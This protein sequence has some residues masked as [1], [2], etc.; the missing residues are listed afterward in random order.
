M[1]IRQLFLPSI[2]VIPTLIAGCALESDP[3]AEQ[4]AVRA[5][6]ALIPGP[7][8]WSSCPILASCFTVTNT[9]DSGAGSLRQAILDANA[10]SGE[11]IIKFDIPGNGPHV[12]QPVQYLPMLLGDTTIDGFSQTGAA[13]ATETSPPQIQIVVNG[14]LSTGFWGLNLG[15]GGNLVQGLTVNDFYP[16][17]AIVINSDDNVVRSNML[18]VDRAATFA[19]PN[20]QAGVLINTGSNNQ[21]GGPDISDRNVISGNGVEG[22]LIFSAGNQVYG[23]A[24]GT[25]FDGSVALGNGSSGVA[26][27][28]DGN[29][30]VGG[31]DE[32]ESN[33]IAHN[34][35][36]GISVLD[37]TGNT[38]SRNILHD[39]AQLGID[40]NDDGVTPNDG[41]LDPD[42][43]AN[44]LQN[45]PRLNRATLD[46]STEYDGKYKAEVD[47]QLKSK[48]NTRYRVEF[49]A[50]SACDPSGRGEAERFLGSRM[51][52]TDATGFM[53]NVWLLPGRVAPSE[54]IAATATEVVLI[55]SEYVATST[56]ELSRCLEVELCTGSTCSSAPA[57]PA[58]SDDV[59]EES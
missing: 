39:N 20:A 54:V 58:C 6:E 28:G 31:T 23:N 35:R 27:H 5:A 13:P 7:L 46:R 48:A 40:L 45:F 12:I 42:V 24:I 52:D 15:V 56:S 49:F 55:G 25:N 9:N 10:A 41:L 34:G 44:E 47:W 11:R 26:L 59:C 2:L 8:T 3:S 33:I 38:L 30:Q 19:R 21:I 32:G 51:L 50:S 53:Q 1:K 14:L 4:D 29:N 57:E 43:G 18:G 16:G 37:G 36:D 17:S 22:V